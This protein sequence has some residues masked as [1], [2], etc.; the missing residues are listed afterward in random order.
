MNG[1]YL[2]G[3]RKGEADG[4]RNPL[5]LLVLLLAPDAMLDNTEGG[6]LALETVLGAGLAFLFR[7]MTIFLSATAEDTSLI[8]SPSS[9]LLEINETCILLHS[10]S[11]QSIIEQ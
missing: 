2:L 3:P 8:M 10:G 1:K 7:P 6:P 9:M 4:G 11:N 5:V